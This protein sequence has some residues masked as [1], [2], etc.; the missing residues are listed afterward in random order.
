MARPNT[1][2]SFE[3]TRKKFFMKLLQDILESY[4]LSSFCGAYDG[5]LRY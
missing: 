1:I 2:I 5:Q 3:A 4:K